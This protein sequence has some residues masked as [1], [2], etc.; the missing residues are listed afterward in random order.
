MDIER[1]VLAHMAF[2]PLISKDIREMDRRL[3]LP[4]KMGLIKEWG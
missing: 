4:E 2:Q 3:F 1:D